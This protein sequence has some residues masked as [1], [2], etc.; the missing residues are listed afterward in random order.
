[1]PETPDWSQAQASGALLTTLVAVVC[2]EGGGAATPAISGVAGQKIILVQMR[3]TP[4]RS[5]TA[6]VTLRGPLVVFARSVDTGLQYAE[7]GISPAAPWAK[8]DIPYGAAV[9]SNALGIEALGFT[10]PGGGTQDADAIFVYY[11][12]SI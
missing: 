9:E 3:L 5:A 4:S 2:A 10:L 11:R 8:I 6:P 12:Q 7:V 1:M